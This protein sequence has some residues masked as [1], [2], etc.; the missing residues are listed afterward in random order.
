M[1]V[2]TRV[3]ADRFM[4]LNVLEE[5]YERL[6]HLIYVAKGNFTNSHVAVE[7]LVNLSKDIRNVHQLE[8]VV[9]IA[10]VEEDKAAYIIL[11]ESLEPNNE[12]YPLHFDD[13]MG[14]HYI[15]I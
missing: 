10:T 3:Y 12:F 6:N 4:Q 5:A 7:Q 9:G 14:R 8:C 2:K 1:A 15:E 13:E 11:F